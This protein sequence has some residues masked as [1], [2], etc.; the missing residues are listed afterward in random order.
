[1]FAGLVAGAWVDRRDRRLAM[2]ATDLVS[3]LL[4]L[5]LLALMASGTLN[6][7]LLLLLVLL[8]WTS[9]AFHGAA[10]DTSYAMLVPERLL[11]RAGP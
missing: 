7:W 6:L 1:M 3:G 10:F 5:A 4:S 2:L 11:P 9:N 8:F